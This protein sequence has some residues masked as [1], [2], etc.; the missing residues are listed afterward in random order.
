MSYKTVAISLFNN[1]FLRK[2]G[3]YMQRS[4]RNPR[5]ARARLLKH[6]NITTILDVGAHEGG[7][8]REARSMGFY[9][10][11][12]S[13]EPNPTVLPRIKDLARSDGK[14]EVI[15]CALS[16]TDGTSQFNVS[17]NEVSSSILDMTALHVE[18]APRSRYVRSIEVPTARLDGAVA[19]IGLLPSDRLLLKID[20]QGAE[21]RVLAG[22]ENMLA[23]PRCR[24]LDLEIS[25]KEVY[26]GQA[27][28]LDLMHKMRSF[29]FE[30]WELMPGIAGPSG[31]LL[32]ADVLLSKG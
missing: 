15:E 13:F 9:G 7:Y 24:A 28:Y 4:A 31:E 27:D 18:A 19:D 20:V 3:L 25:F 21:H 1:Q 17:E 6:L 14:W 26:D 12:F 30:I 29:G 11:A 32:Q 2:S 16:D 23:D 5:V 8:I 22:G 10:Q